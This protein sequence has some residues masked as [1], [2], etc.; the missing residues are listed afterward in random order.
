MKL[1]KRLELTDIQSLPNIGG[2]DWPLVIL[3]PEL[4]DEMV[5][6]LRQLGTPRSVAASSELE[7]GK[8]LYINGR[9]YIIGPLMYDLAR[10][11]RET[12]PKPVAD[13]PVST[14]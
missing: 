10:E 9:I 3:S 12:S 7:D 1:T 2:E 6:R 14:P 8:P 13:T 11:I 5:I 4:A